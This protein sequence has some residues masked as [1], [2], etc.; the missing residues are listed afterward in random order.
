M[1]TAKYPMN[2]FFTREAKTVNNPSTDIID[3][4]VRNMDSRQTLM[5][6]DGDLTTNFITI[7][8]DKDGSFTLH[9]D[10]IG[11]RYEFKT[12]DVSHV[13][14]IVQTYAEGTQVYRSMVDWT[15]LPPNS[16]TPSTQKNLMSYAWNDPYIIIK[17]LAA[18]AISVAGIVYTASK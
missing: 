15:I 10:R 14:N 8:H 12:T 11:S 6:G 16:I 18:L 5:L 4:A 7:F 1:Y 13:I 3:K 17:L 9:D 2:L